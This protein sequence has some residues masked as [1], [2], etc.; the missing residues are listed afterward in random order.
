MNAW[1]RGALLSPLFCGAL[2]AAPA[3]QPTFDLQLITSGVTS[4]GGTNYDLYH[5]NAINDVADFISVTLVLPGS[6]VNE[7][8]ASLPGV[9]TFRD[10]TD[11]PA[12][13]PIAFDLPETFFVLPAGAAGTQ[14]SVDVVDDSTLLA[15]SYTLPGSTPVIPLGTSTVAVLSVPAGF[16][17]QASIA[18]GASF[19]GVAVDPL[20]EIPEPTSLLLALPCV[21]LAPRRR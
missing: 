17:L 6:F 21:A 12:F 3:T 13:P 16:D 15:A 14:L 18:S 5:L 4:P 20:P 7:A 19:N 8:T 9:I 1:F 11:L 10:S 2:F